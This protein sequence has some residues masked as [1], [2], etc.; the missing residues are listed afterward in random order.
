MEGFE[1]AA[2]AQINMVTDFPNI[3]Q[4]AVHIEND[5]LRSRSAHLCVLGH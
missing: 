2:S 3:A 4:R 5:R 1:I